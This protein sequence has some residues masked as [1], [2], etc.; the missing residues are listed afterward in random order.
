[1]GGHYVR[2][3]RKKKEKKNQ[4]KALTSGNA[5]IIIGGT[6]NQQQQQKNIMN[7]QDI[8]DIITAA[9][10]ANENG[11]HFRLADLA[12]DG[13]G[14]WSATIEGDFEDFDGV[15]VLE[16]IEAAL[17]KAGVARKAT[18]DVRDQLTGWIV[19]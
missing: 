8:I 4:K 2:P 12:G 18:F 14:A 6:I 13:T 16:G 3:R 19:F 10:A 17:V 5:C 15:A 9:I 11:K 7:K 1:M